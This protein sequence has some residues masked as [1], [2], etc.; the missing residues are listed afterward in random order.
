M[1][2]SKALDTVPHKKQFVKLEKIRKDRGAV[3]D[4]E[5]ELSLE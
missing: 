1:C 3:R 5:V 4:R 2:I